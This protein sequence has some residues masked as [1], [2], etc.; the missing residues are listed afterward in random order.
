MSAS[1][2][3]KRSDRDFYHQAHLQQQVM[4][5]LVDMLLYVCFLFHLPIWHI[6]DPITFP[7]WPQFYILIMW[8]DDISHCVSNVA[9]LDKCS[10]CDSNT[11]PN[12][13]PPKNTLCPLLTS[14]CMFNCCQ[15]KQ[16]IIINQTNLSQPPTFINIQLW[17]PFGRET[18]PIKPLAPPRE[19]VRHA[20]HVLRCVP[21]T[22]DSG[23]QRQEITWATCGPAHLITLTGVGASV[24]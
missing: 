5:E 22:S 13:T 19:T 16:P 23:S 1:M 9:M 6:C 18:T 12:R 2:D 21:P 11:K 8:C 10:D 20:P 15:I 3:V 14:P 4:T 24:H 7:M 17:T